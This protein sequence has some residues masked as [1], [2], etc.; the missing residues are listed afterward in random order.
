MGAEYFYKKY[1][2][3]MKKE[4][5]CCPLCHREF[6]QEQEVRELILEVRHFCNMFFSIV[7]SLDFVCK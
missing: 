2:Q 7:F 6:E 4:N 1:V 3:D 5:P